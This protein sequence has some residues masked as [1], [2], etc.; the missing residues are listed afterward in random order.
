MDVSCLGEALIDFVAT[1]SGVTLEDARGFIKA[2]GGAPANVAAGV[3]K[4]GR[5]SAFL[6]KVGADPFGYYLRD[7][8]VNAGIDVKGMR[9]D[10]DHRTGLAFVSLQMNGERDFCFFR[11]PSADML[12][13]SAEIDDDMISSSSIFHFGSITLISDPSKDATLN[14][15]EIARSSGSLI[16]FDPNWRPALW[17]DLDNARDTILSVMTDIDVLKLSEEELYFLTG[18]DSLESGLS[19]LMRINPGIL[20]AVITQGMHGSTWRRNDG[21]HGTHPGYSVRAIDTTGAGDGFVAGMLT[22]ILD[23]SSPPHDILDLSEKDMVNL[24]ERANQVGALTT[25][26]KGAIPALPTMDQVRSF[27]EKNE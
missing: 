4:L 7:T 26:S 9:F 1:E 2:P 22:G 13:C 10:P 23:Y 6:G 27:S 11:N 12:Y 25:M 5:T 16:S 19:H 8:F 24:F 3:A 21:I 14:A 15:L 18:A 17:P 20:L